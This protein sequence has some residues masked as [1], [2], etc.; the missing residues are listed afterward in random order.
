MGIFNKRGAPRGRDNRKEDR[1]M[2]RAT[3]SDCGKNCEVPFRPTGDKPIYCSN[4]FQREESP[5]GRDDRPRRRNDRSGGRD[6]R[7]DRQMHRA[8]C[9][10][11]GKNCE[12]PFKPTGNKPVYCSNC[13]E[14][15]SGGSSR[16]AAKNSARPDKKY[17]EMNEKLNKILFLL[18]KMSP[19]EEDPSPKPKKKKVV[20]EAPIKEETAAKKAVKKIAK[21]SPAKKTVK[22]AAK[23][24]PAKKTVKKVAKKAPAK[25]TVKK[26]AAK[27]VK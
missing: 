1:Q 18:Q 27:K 8:H 22:K 19:Q 9:A 2:H 16:P 15:E 20:E 23:K 5:R 12:V 24:A 21:K 26:A 14:R 6:D 10:D 3:C 11:C 13:F 17:D 7:G 4:C 25:K